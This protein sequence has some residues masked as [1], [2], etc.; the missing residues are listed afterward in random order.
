MNRGITSD[1]AD[2]YALLSYEN[3][4]GGTIGIAWLRTTCHSERGLRT[5]ITE[6]FRSDVV[7]AEVIAYHMVGISYSLH[8][9]A[10]R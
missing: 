1:N 2:S 3:N 9:K 5:G 6:H 4:A 7:T 10:A 8:T